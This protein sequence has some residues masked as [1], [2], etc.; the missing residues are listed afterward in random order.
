VGP[1]NSCEP[2]SMLSSLAYLLEVL[3]PR[4][5]PRAEPSSP[6]MTSNT[7]NV[8][9]GHL[10]MRYSIY[11]VEGVRNDPSKRVTVSALAASFGGKE[12]SSKAMRNA[13]SF[14]RSGLI[15]N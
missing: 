8:V 11:Y 7:P 14:I 3:V 15:T 10:R 9:S 2:I 13:R 12:V 5:I 1:S 6:S 4:I